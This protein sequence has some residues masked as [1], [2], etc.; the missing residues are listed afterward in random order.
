MPKP[1][2]TLSW[3]RKKNLHS[4]YIIKQYWT[5]MPAFVNENY[6]KNYLALFL[7]LLSFPAKV[8]NAL[9]SEAGFEEF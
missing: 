8:N 1:H 7:Y 3:K 6:F 4:L 5:Y 2:Q 9:W